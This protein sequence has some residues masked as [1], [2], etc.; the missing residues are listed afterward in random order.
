VL[1][2][3][4]RH[5]DAVARVRAELDRARLDSRRRHVE[6]SL[7]LLACERGRVARGRSGAALADVLGTLAAL[8]GRL[9]AVAT[10]LAREG[11][12]EPTERTLRRTI[13]LVNDAAAADRAVVRA[14]RRLAAE[15]AVIDPAITPAATLR[16][17]VTARLASPDLPFV[18]LELDEAE[19][20]RA[21]AAF[22][23]AAR[24]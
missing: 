21:V 3:V 11:A 15:L 6:Q 18:H 23:A 4:A 19:T 10:E 24:A 2:A 13:G 16:R 20:R 17:W 8:G 12:A 22:V 9:D 7:E 14:V 1:Q 5:A